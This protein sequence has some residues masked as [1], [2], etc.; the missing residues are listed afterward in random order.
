MNAISATINWTEHTCARRSFQI[1]E[2]LPCEGQVI[3]EGGYIRHTCAAVHEITGKIA[4]RNIGENKLFRFYIAYYDDEILVNDVEE[5]TLLSYW[6]PE[7]E[8]FQYY[9]IPN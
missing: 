9:A 1:V 4:G 8:S 7:G 3:E 6:E 2:E 5:G